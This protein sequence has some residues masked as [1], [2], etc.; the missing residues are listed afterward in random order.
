MR[1]LLIYPKNSDSFWSFKHALKFIGKK[2]PQPPLGLLTIAAMLPQE[3]QKRL[4][5]MNVTPLRDRDLQW[6]DA[7][8]ISAMSIQRVSAREVIERCKAA[9]VTTVAGGPLFTTEPDDFRDV[10]HL[11]LGE[12]EIALPQFLED[13]ENGRA[14]RVYTSREHA[15]LEKTPVPLWELVDMRKYAFMNVQYSRGCPFDCDFCSISSLF[16]HKARTTNT[17][18]LLV[19]LDALHSRGWKG[20]VFFVDDNFIGNKARLKKEVLPGLIQWMQSN[21]RPFTFSTEASINL[22]DDE[23]LMRLMVLAG[24]DAVF[25]GIETP[26]ED[27]LLECNK[28]QNRNRDLLE[29]V[30]R[31]QNAGLQV[32]AGF[33]VGFDHDPPSIFESVS[34]FIQNSGIVGAMVGL[35]NAP[36]NTRLYRRLVDEGRLL[37][38]PTGD[39]TDFSINFVPKMDYDT[40]IKGYR[41]IIKSIYSPKPYYERIR[42]FLQDY[43][44]FQDKTFRL[45]FSHVRALLRSIVMLGII[46]KER[47]CYWKL[48]LWTAFRRPRLFPLAITFAIYGQHFR[49]VLGE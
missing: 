17:A 46:G 4:V 42:R 14:E 26:N 44:P 41:A 10:N 25:V 20:E 30:K 15:G 48:F 45:K 38:T 28:L 36:C 12:G 24:F 32:T 37:A 49:K 7:V 35:L 5:D 9:A 40:L 11:V 3:W 34:T 47:V 27:S 21:G 19:N 2:A 23:E 29:S 13:L 31:I 22:A 8:F 33:I 18:R 39:N 16:G 1:V 6:A 43:R